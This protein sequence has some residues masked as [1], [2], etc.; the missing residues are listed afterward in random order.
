M[1]TT[2]EST[3]PETDP[4]TDAGLRLVVDALERAENRASIEREAMRGEFS[5][6]LESLAL[7]IDAAVGGVRVDLRS[8]VRGVILSNVIALMVIAALAGVTSYLKLGATTFGASP[9]TAET[10]TTATATAVAPE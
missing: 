10:E 4:S 8:A 5:R 6:S 9:T 3:T 1:S 7:R 2:T